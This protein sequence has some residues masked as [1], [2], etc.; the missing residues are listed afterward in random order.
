MNWRQVLRDG[1]LCPAPRRGGPPPASKDDVG[2][3]QY[4]GPKLCPTPHRCCSAQ[5]CAPSAT[6]ARR[7]YGQGHREPG[8][9]A[10]LPSNPDFRAKRGRP[11]PATEARFQQPGAHARP[12]RRGHLPA[13][14]LLSPLEE[15]SREGKHKSEQPLQPPR[16]GAR[17]RLGD[18]ARQPSDTRH[19]GSPS[20]PRRGRYEQ[21]SPRTHC[22]WG[23]PRTPM[24]RTA[25]PGRARH[26]AKAGA[27][28]PP[29]APQALA[30]A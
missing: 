10:R 27:A 7:G 25:P 13:H 6:P 9:T 26:P 21:S 12:E 5:P 4:L 11:R 20:R 1:P 8:T 22:G 17:S 30:A 29:P 15:G 18:G 23:A 14:P 16:N 19:V 3:S 28:A 2:K 24:A